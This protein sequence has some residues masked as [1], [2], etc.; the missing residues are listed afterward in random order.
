MDSIRNINARILALRRICRRAIFIVIFIYCNLYDSIFRSRSR[1][2]EIS[3][4]V[5]FFVQIRD[6]V[7]F[8]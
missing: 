8:A 7:S 6:N 5:W 4:F 3:G 1:S 2:T